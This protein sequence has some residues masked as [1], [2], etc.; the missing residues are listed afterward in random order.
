MATNY[1]KLLVSP[2]VTFIIIYFFN[3][4]A[5]H[6]LLF[7]HLKFFNKSDIVQKD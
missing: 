5:N 4:N 7:M 3:V 1:N 2:I 6:F